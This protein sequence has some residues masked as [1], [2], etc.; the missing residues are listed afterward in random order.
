MQNHPTHRPSPSTPAPM[1]QIHALHV[2]TTFSDASAYQAHRQLL[3][4]YDPIAVQEIQ[5]FRSID[6]SKRKSEIADVSPTFFA[7]A[8]V[9]H[10][11]PHGVPKT[12]AL[13][14]RLL[15]RYILSLRGLNWRQV[16]FE[17]GDYGRPFAFHPNLPKGFQ[18]SISHDADWV[19]CASILAEKEKLPLVKNVG[20]DVMRLSIPWDDVDPEGMLDMMRDQLS[21]FE[22]RSIQAHP[23]T[24]LETLFS[25]WVLKEAYI[26]ARSLG[27]RGFPELN[28]VEFHIGEN[29]KEVD[30]G[31]G[32]K[33]VEG[34]L[35]GED[36]EGW[37]F[38]LKK[39]DEGR[40]L[41]A[42]AL[43]VEGETDVGVPDWE[44]EILGR[45]VV[46]EKLESRRDSV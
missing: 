24:E 2:P 12:G 28:R 22:L 27:L 42:V 33:K 20:V 32:W 17:K 15:P 7:R 31:G 23:R 46:L 30:Q 41:V 38:G 40:Y 44:V 19:I 13:I 35:D 9:A 8:L 43:E 25:Y 37:W 1:I 26:K 29:G 4:D 18:Y 45:E 34:V 39:F 10:S 6:D 14:S 11:F 16:R 3:L 21:P 5:S 36:L